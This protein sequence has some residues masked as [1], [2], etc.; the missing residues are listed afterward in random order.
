MTLAPL[1]LPV[2]THLAECV[3]DHC[4]R[5]SLCCENIC[6]AVRSGTWFVEIY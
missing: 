3:G 6:H 4:S 2:C 1:A 5:W